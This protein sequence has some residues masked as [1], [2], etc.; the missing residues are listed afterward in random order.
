MEMWPFYWLKSDFAGKS[1]LADIFDCSVS[2][3]ISSVFSCTIKRFPNTSIMI[4]GM[5]DVKDNEVSLLT[6]QSFAE[7]AAR[8]HWWKQKPKLISLEN[9]TNRPDPIPLQA[10]V[11]YLWLQQWDKHYLWLSVCRSMIP[12]MAFDVLH[13]K[14]TEREVPAMI[15]K[16]A[17]HKT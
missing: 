1:V 16:H 5:T 8:R 13:T 10:I 12:S 17:F 4:Q 9:N 15:P 2:N 11:Q 3:N 7:T 14:Q 6:L